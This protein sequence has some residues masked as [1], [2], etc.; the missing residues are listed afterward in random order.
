MTEP[1]R[2]L[3][4]RI[5]A[6]DRDAFCILV[7]RYAPRLFNAVFHMTSDRVA[8]EDLVQDALVG[9]YNGLDRFRGDA[10]FY[11]WLYRIAFNRTLNWIRKGRGKLTFES[12]D[13]DEG[14]R[15]REVADASD[16]PLARAEQRELGE[17]LQG[18]IASLNEANRIVFTMREV[19]G[20][21]YEEIARMLDCTQE[22]VRTR[23]HRAKKELK[24][25][26]R[27]YLESEV[28]R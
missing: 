2:A 15:P 11:T 9:A 16:D 4:E 14:E 26:L 10:G 23:L 21:E 25:R 3:L 5:R 6:G 7:E 13:A 17:A 27:P 28:T 20:F 1:E 22:A 18:A 19:D 24:A 12:L 8:A